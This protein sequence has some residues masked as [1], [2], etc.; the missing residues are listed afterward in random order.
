MVSGCYLLWVLNH[1]YTVT[2]S[3][4]KLKPVVTLPILCL[5]GLGTILGAGVYV[6]IGE[7]AGASSIYAPF[8]FLIAALVASFVGVSYAE[9]SSH[10]PK[11]AGE[12]RYVREIFGRQWLTR[13]TG[14]SIMMTGA[15]S[16]AVMV[17]GF[18]G[19]ASEFIHGSPS[20]LFGFQD[21]FLMI[22]FALFITGI[23]C[24]GIFQSALVASVVTVVEV[25]GILLVIWVGHDNLADYVVSF[26]DYTPGFE[27]ANWMAISTGSFIAFYAYIGF[28]D[29]VN[30]AEEVVEPERNLPRAIFVSLVV[31]S[32]LYFLVA[33]LMVTALPA[34]VLASSTA[35]FADLLRYKSSIPPQVISVISMIAIFN[36]A[37]VQLIMGSR[38]LFGMADQGDVPRFFAAVHVS[39]KTPIRATLF[40]GLVISALALWLPLGT[41][42][43]LT[44]LI[45][46]SVFVLVCLALVVLKSN[47]KQQT[48]AVRY[49]IWVPVAG[50]FFCLSLLAL[51]IFSWF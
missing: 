32:V 5:Y 38:V 9:L 49:P 21:Q 25:L 46:L 31:S 22:G 4:P 33:A 7:I 41:L 1:E 35:P 13:L 17:R 12:A 28:E 36:G 45:I 44:S 18:V 26:S 24:W 37:L 14:F 10:F 50:A 16:A 39:R 8:A 20:A 47:N 29:M 15:V 43:R 3:Q 34:D 42:A 11:S 23:A 27:L 51:Q 19:Y 48:Q 30:I 2:M 6:L 40:F